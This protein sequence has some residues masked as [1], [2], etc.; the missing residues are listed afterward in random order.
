MIYKLIFKK[1]TFINLEKNKF[2]IVIKKKG[3]FLFPSG[4]GLAT[5]DKEHLYHKSLINADFVFFDSGFFVFLL[6][7]FKNIK[8][9]KFSGYLFIN[10]FIKYLTKN[11]NIKILSVDPNLNL[12]KSNKN[13]FLNIGLKKKNITNYISPI[14][15]KSK[16]EDKKLV[17]IID[18]NKPD[19]I[20]INIGGNVQEILGFYLKKKIKI[21]K[22]RILCTGAA[23]SFFTGDQAP[24]NNFIDKFYLGWLIRIIFN[25]K[26]FLLRYIKTFKLI[27]SIFNEKIDLK[28]KNIS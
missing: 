12:S 18:K 23:I 20:L 22:Y 24:I 17:K 25:P 21:K 13:F 4:P 26:R 5:L 9:N 6:R 14:Y 10:L 2:N 11:K 1:I 28:I 16:I 8:V 7:I 15:N 27:F 19:F 3:L